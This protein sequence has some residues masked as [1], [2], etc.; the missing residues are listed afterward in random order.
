MLK[1]V[2]FMRFKK[3]DTINTLEMGPKVAYQCNCAC[4][5][6]TPAQLKKN[7]DIQK[8][9]RTQGNIIVTMDLH[10]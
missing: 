3:V 8:D 6:S 2:I 10:K 7:A 5:K 4:P 1:E 9:N